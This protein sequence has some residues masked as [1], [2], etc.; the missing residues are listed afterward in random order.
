MTPTL[1]LILAIVYLGIWLRRG[2][3]L[4]ACRA[5]V[6]LAL[7]GV[8]IVRQISIICAF[9]TLLMLLFGSWDGRTL[10]VFIVS[11]SISLIITNAFERLQRLAA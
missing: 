5:A 9:A 4:T 2:G 6:V 11:T 8:L 1:I 7:A 10:S 3:W